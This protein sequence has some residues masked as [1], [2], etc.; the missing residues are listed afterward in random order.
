MKSCNPVK[1]E[2]WKNGKVENWKNGRKSCNPVILKSCK[3]S[4]VKHR[5][6]PD[7]YRGKMKNEE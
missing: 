6:S 2:E 4:N 5:M 7:S 3:M 1:I